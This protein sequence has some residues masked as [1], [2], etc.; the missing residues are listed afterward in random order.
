MIDFLRQRKHA[1]MQAFAPGAP[2]HDALVDLAKFCR[3]FGGDVL[4]GNHDLTMVL[5]GRRE[6]YFRIID[7][8]HFQPQQLLELYSSVKQPQQENR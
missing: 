8:L 7:H 1:Y 2:G 3:A 4:P 5:A 6:A